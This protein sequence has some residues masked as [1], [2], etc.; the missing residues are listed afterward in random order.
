MRSPSILV[1]LLLL[2]LG[3]AARLAARDAMLRLEEGVDLDYAGKSL[4]EA[5]TGFESARAAA[6]PQSWERVTLTSDGSLRLGRDV[7]MVLLPAARGET[8]LMVV[9]ENGP[10][11]EPIELAREAIVGP[12]RV[13]L[14][15]VSSSGRTAELLIRDAAPAPL[16]VPA[17]E[18]AKSP[19]KITGIDRPRKLMVSSTDE[20]VLD[21]AE[22]FVAELNA[23]KA[24]EES[25]RIAREYVPV[26]SPLAAAAGVPAARDYTDPK[27]IAWPAD[28]DIFAAGVTLRLVRGE[29]EALRNLS[30]SWSYN[31]DGNLNSTPRVRAKSG[32]DGT[33]VK[34][35]G[36]GDAF[37]YQLHMLEKEGRISVD[38]E[39]FVNVPLG[40]ET[41]FEM[42]GPRD[43]LSAVVGARR[44]GARGVMLMLDNQSGD[45]GF[46]GSINT[47]V[48]VND[49][50]TVTL[51]KNVFTR[52]E[53]Q[54]SNVPILGDVP[55]VGPA[56]R[57]ESTRKQDS[58]Y[59]LFA[60][61]A[62]Q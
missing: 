8:R 29:A 31:S 26:S 46:L 50:Q 58:S 30:S 21:F 17:N 44:Q 28:A 49:G 59:A 39:T 53:S 60:T 37:E 56:F 52:T 11:E 57:N 51:A 5:V 47:R 48:R 62:L 15:T 40:G 10:A 9:D 6:L 45:W 24:A 13:I 27:N 25:A 3:T 22:K 19:T 54:S 32:E 12:L 7:H 14:V 34:V 55:F 43:A 1:L 36:P 35:G 2:M 33:D 16:L 20:K 38:S 61:V 23:G 4:R 18:G 41:L 42:M